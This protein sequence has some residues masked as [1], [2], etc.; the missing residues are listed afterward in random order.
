MNK[1]NYS[2]DDLSDE[3]PEIDYYNNQN[4]VD[5][6]HEI[7][8]GLKKRG[9]SALFAQTQS[10]KSEVMIR[11]TKCI[12][13]DEELKKY[14]IK[15]IKKL[16]I[17]LCLSSCESKNYLADKFSE[18][19][20][21]KV[22]HIDDMDKI[23][24]NNEKYLYKKK[25]KILCN[26]KEI[27]AHKL[28]IKIAS[29]TFICFDEVHCAEEKNQTID[30]FRK[31]LDN[32]KKNTYNI[33]ISA[34][35]YTLSNQDNKIKYV[36]M[37]PGKNYFGISEIKKKNLIHTSRDLTNKKYVERLFN[38]IL[39]KH[40]LVNN[41]IKGWI[42]IRSNEININKIFTEISKYLHDN[43]IKFNDKP[44]IF[45]QDNKN[46][47]NDHYLKKE[48][49]KLRFMFVKERIRQSIPI[50]KN[51]IIALYDRPE[52]TYAHSTV[53]GFLGRACGYVKHNIL[54]FTCIEHVDQHIKYMENNYNRKDI[55]DDQKL[56]YKTK[57]SNGYREN[58]SNAIWSKH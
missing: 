19:E 58:K 18:F 37:K 32:Y 17:I 40:K 41:T 25:N 49:N 3:H 9:I 23:I 15:N 1:L 20:N 6:T 55:P 31:L 34:T 12:D 50:Y 42:I 46:D 56:I 43:N 36:I 5:A 33:Y 39:K 57:D 2:F 26:K 10:G 38:Y 11:L 54:I 35:P 16:Y 48:P 27:K 4:I 47:L 53:Q 7:L 14:G 29:D 44:V 8:C 13:N 22:L 45:D 52:T 28:L 21:V 30:K 24:K 51:H